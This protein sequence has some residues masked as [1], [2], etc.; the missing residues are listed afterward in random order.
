MWI[1][2]PDKSHFGTW[3][4]GHAIWFGKE[5]KAARL[6]ITDDNSLLFCN[7]FSFPAA[8]AA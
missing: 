6:F 4:Q 8:G 2:Y 1:R 5:G 3:Q 7:F